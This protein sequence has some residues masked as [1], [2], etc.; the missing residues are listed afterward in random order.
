MEHKKSKKIIKES[1][2][3]GYKLIAKYVTQKKT[4]VPGGTIQ[5]TKAGA[6]YLIK[7]IYKG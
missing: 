6:E 3:K 1:D 2:R 7:H 5:L 4:H